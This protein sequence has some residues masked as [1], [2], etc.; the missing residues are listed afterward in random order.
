MAMLD[1]FV[2]THIHIG[3]A[4]IRKN[5]IVIDEILSSII[6]ETAILK[7]S[8]TYLKLLIWI[9]GPPDSSEFLKMIKSHTNRMEFVDSVKHSLEKYSL[10]G[11]DLDWEFPNMYNRGRLHFSQ[12]L[13]E[14]RRAFDREGGNFLLSVAVAPIEGIA[15]FAYDIRTINQYCDYVNIMVSRSTI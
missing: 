13:Y 2:C 6:N 8:N 7:R 3:I 11:I 1:P 4:S 15:Y 5:R 12:L 9:G 10:D 14:I